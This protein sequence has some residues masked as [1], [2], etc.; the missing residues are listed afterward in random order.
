M[1]THSL[2]WLRVIFALSSLRTVS[3]NPTPEVKHKRS[4]TNR[5][6]NSYSMKGNLTAIAICL[7]FARLVRCLLR[8]TRCEPERRLIKHQ[9]LRPHHQ[10]TRNR[11]HLLRATGQVITVGAPL[12][13]RNICSSVRGRPVRGPCRG[14]EIR[15]AVT[16]MRT[17]Q[18]ASTGAPDSRRR[19]R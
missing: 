9:Q 11:K 6:S 5:E 17:L 15:R 16:P 4:K 10:R 1:R 8:D 7:Y 14:G 19:F 3:G 13:A 2:P 18:R 12:A